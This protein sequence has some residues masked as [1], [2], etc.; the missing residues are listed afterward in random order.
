MSVST[1]PSES[2]R[3]G[4]SLYLILFPAEVE[5]EVLQ[6]MEA[7]GVP[8]YTEFPRMVGRGEHHRHFNNPIW[9]GSVGAVFSVIPTERASALLEPLVTLSDS[10]RER[11]HGL[12][13][14]HIFALPCEQII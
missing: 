1:E 6:T 9:P 2:A 8:G 7:A 5:E 12:Q 4:L 14:L 10:L 13:G 11:T 3:Q